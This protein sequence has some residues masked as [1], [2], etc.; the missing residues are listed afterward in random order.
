MS[1]FSIGKNEAKQKEREQAK[2]L[3]STKEEEE[4][5]KRAQ[6]AMEKQSQKAEALD[7]KNKKL[8][9]DNIKLIHELEEKSKDRSLSED[10]QLQAK[11]E[12]QTLRNQ[13]NIKSNIDS[14][15]KSSKESLKMKLTKIQAN[16]PIKRIKEFGS[17]ATQLI[18][19]SAESAGKITA[20]SQGIFHVFAGKIKEWMDGNDPEKYQQDPGIFGGVKKWIHSGLY[21]MAGMLFKVF[22]KIDNVFGGFNDTSGLPSGLKKDLDNS[23][24]SIASAPPTE[25]KFPEEKI[26]QSKEDEYKSQFANIDVYNQI[27]ELDGKSKAIAR[28]Y[29]SKGLNR[30]IDKIFGKGASENF[31]ENSRIE[32]FI[33]AGLMSLDED[34]NLSILKGSD[35][36]LKDKEKDIWNQYVGNLAE[37]YNR[38]RLISNRAKNVADNQS[39]KVTVGNKSITDLLNELENETDEDKKAALESQLKEVQDDLL[40][41]DN[42]KKAEEALAKLENREGLT[43]QD[44]SLVEDYLLAKYGKT[45]NVNYTGTKNYYSGNAGK[46]GSKGEH[47]T[48][49][50]I[51]QTSELNLTDNS[52]NTTINAINELPY[53]ESIS[54]KA[55]ANETKIEAFDEN[56]KETLSEEMS[57]ESDKKTK[58]FVADDSSSNDSRTNPEGGSQTG[59]TGN[60]K[61]KVDNVSNNDQVISKRITVINTDPGDLVTSQERAL[62]Y[63]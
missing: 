15:G 58:D 24:K 61:Y 43:S 34:G 40:K 11:A 6:K 23:E 37:F 9:R 59:R 29:K 31:N 51:N 26:E 38:S 18:L 17:S 46:K 50:N 3:G 57:K 14:A 13:S 22:G 62:G 2:W 8:D 7:S 49:V 21:N 47:V 36:K 20:I 45:A 44:E 19:D 25:E 60:I 12:A 32:N 1:I 28:F 41:E 39:R 16:N 27:K 54:T 35:L 52:I 56:T 5:G 10:E 30:I 42:T 55:Q 63:D 33:S 53:D 48:N 4:A